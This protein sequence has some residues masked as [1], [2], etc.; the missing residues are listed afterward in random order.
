MKAARPA[1]A[2]IGLWKTTRIRT[3]KTRAAS[4]ARLTDPR[5]VGGLDVRS[6]RRRRDI[7]LASSRV[8]PRPVRWRLWIVPAGVPRCF[9][10]RLRLV[11]DTDA[12]LPEGG[13]GVFEQVALGIEPA[14][15]DVLRKALERGLRR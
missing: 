2:A 11:W 14:K 1:A 13:Q 15:R 8:R 7:S 9:R 3:A 10:R 5:S 4:A 6:S 12:T